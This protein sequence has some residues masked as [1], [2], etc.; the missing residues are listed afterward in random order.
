MS[1]F[2]TSGTLRHDAPSYVERDAD[3]TLYEQLLKGAFCYVLTSRQMGKSSLMARTSKK[4]RDQGLQVITLD[5]TA[6]GQNLTLEQWYDGLVLKMGEDLDLEDPLDSFWRANSKLSPVQ[7]FF[8]S[9]RQVILPQR[10]SNTIFF[11]DEIDAVKNLC[12]SPDEFFA[13]IRECY[14]RRVFDPQFQRITFCLLGVASPSELISSPQTTPFNIGQRIELRDFNLAEASLM[15]HGLQHG[16]PPAQA[17]T[18]SEQLLQRVFWWTHGHPY[19][20][21]RLCLEIFELNTRPNTGLKIDSPEKVNELCATIFLSAR[22]RERDDNL[23]FV[24]ERIRRSDEQIESLLALY[25]QI[26]Q[27]TPVKDDEFDPLINVLHL[28]GIVRIENGFLTVRNRIYHQVFDRH[29][30]LA[31]LPHLG[32]K[33]RYKTEAHQLWLQGCHHFHQATEIS[34]YKACESFEAALGHDP[35][36]AP[37][38]AGLGEAH[39]ALSW[40]GYLSPKAAFPRMA[41]ATHKALELNGYSA[42]VRVALGNNKWF[43]NHDPIGARQEFSLALDLDP[44]HAPAHL[45]L[46]LLEVAQ[47]RRP[48]A[49]SAAKRSLELAQVQPSINLQAGVAL[50]LARELDEVLELAWRM[51]DF[52]PN[53][54]GAHWLLG[55]ACWEKGMPEESISQLQ[56]AAALRGGPSVQAALGFVHGQLGQT[57]AAEECLAQLRA[58]QQRKYLSPFWTAVVLSGLYHLQQALDSL[59]KAA[60][61]QDPNL[62]FLSQSPYFFLLHP[63]P[64]FQQLLRK[65]N[66][67]TP[68]IRDI[69]ILNA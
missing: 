57:Q 67:D 10:Q 27:G 68:V 20:T 36:C 39:L 49:I 34:L 59:Q 69:S 28:S 61:E 60:L 44:N 16:L 31:Q 2:A 12:F 18:I 7:R 3:Q 13:A 19:L 23:L 25:Q 38:L 37:A 40:Y 9:I 47:N 56:K 22:S 45:Q 30:I 6:I 50:W 15:K 63:L 1:F 4:L 64:E 53:F 29:W 54:F 24:R 58:L 26:H 33:L 66:I 46:A 32:S 55:M 35:D 17:E 52:D 11:I 65:M 5:L 48:F 43:I 21:Q 8:S 62:L 14:N 42:E 41:E 51:L